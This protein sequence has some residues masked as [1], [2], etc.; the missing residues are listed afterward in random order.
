MKIYDKNWKLGYCKLY[1]QAEKLQYQLEKPI[2]IQNRT[3]EKQTK[4]NLVRKHTNS[5]INRIWPIKNKRKKK[6]KQQLT[7]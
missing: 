3:A 6:K 4:Q 2:T 1:K 7:D 5:I